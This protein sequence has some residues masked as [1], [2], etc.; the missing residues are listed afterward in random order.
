MTEK[1]FRGNNLYGCDLKNILHFLMRTGKMF[2]KEPRYFD[3]TIVHAI[4]YA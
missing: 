4:G 3:H 2:E 1:F